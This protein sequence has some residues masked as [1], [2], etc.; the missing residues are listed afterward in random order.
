MGKLDKK[1]IALLG[2]FFL[3]F[4]LFI[5]LLFFRDN[6]SM[7]TR[8]SEDTQPSAEKSL[9]FAWPLQTKITDNT[10]IKISVFVRSVSGKPIENKV[11]MIKTSLGQLNVSSGAS[12]KQ[13]KAEFELSSREAGEAKLDVTIDNTL[14][15][16]Q[17]VT[18]KFE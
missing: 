3:S 10:P 5:S 7:I 4:L 13:G 16:K 8:A 9:I 12:D 14:Q 11:I 2:V 15:I 6:I 18:V 17:S 1:F